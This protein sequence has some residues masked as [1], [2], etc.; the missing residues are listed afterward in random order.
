[1]AANHW[2]EEGVN[3]R[4]ADMPRLT[5]EAKSVDQGHPKPAASSLKPWAPSFAHRPALFFRLSVLPLGQVLL[6]L[7][8]TDGLSIADVALMSEFCTKIRDC[9]LEPFRCEALRNCL[10]Q[11]AMCLGNSKASVLPEPSTMTSCSRK[12]GL[13][14]VL[15]F[16]SISESYSISRCSSTQS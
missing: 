11:S 12:P 9:A 15:F 16:S 2:G 1:M 8:F 3:S 7:I 13:R 5:L 6:H 4:H 14:V 10:S